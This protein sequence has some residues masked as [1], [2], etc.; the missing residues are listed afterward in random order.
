MDRFILK[1]LY[2]ST[3]YQYILENYWIRKYY[4]VCTVFWSF[5]SHEW[6]RQNF[7]LQYQYNT[8]QTSDENKE[9]YQLGDYWLI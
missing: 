9:K 3:E 5:H 1:I 4:V 8:R 6:S 2:I 7:S